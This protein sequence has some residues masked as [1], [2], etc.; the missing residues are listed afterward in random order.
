MSKFANVE[1]LDHTVTLCPT[2]RA[3]GIGAGYRANTLY[4]PMLARKRITIPSQPVPVAQ[5]IPTVIAA[6][7]VVA[8]QTQSVNIV[9][10]VVIPFFVF[11]QPRL[12]SSIYSMLY[13]YTAPIA[14]MGRNN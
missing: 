12:V 10:P 7:Q 9:R 4:K 8:R 1:I 11:F 6:S 3:R 13:R 14:P 2:R 5:P